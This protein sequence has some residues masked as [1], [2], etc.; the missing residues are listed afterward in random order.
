[1]NVN[2]FLRDE[3]IVAWNAKTYRSITGY[4]NNVSNAFNITDVHSSVNKKI[5]EAFDSTSQERYQ[6]TVLRTLVQ[7]YVD[8]LYRLSDE[9]RNIN[10]SIIRTAKSNIKGRG[11]EIQPC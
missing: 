7:Q 11:C 5:N 3:F 8:E 4:L 1:M 10:D 9:G 6:K 2:E